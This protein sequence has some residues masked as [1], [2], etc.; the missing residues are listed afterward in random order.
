MC[1]ASVMGSKVS[2]QTLWSRDGLASLSSAVIP[3]GLA[4][5]TKS[6][7]L[8]QGCGVCVC[9]ACG[10]S[11]MTQSRTHSLVSSPSHRRPQRLPSHPHPPSVAE[12]FPTPA[13]TLPEAVLL[14]VYE[15]V[16]SLCNA[17]K[18]EPSTDLGPGILPCPGV[19][20]EGVLS[21]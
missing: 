17:S 2:L 15:E 6:R 19:T 1:A 4:S 21:C 13:E 12:Q 20:A 7:T 11:V 3:A 9:R 8:A 16:F 5:V 14:P 18:T 10:V